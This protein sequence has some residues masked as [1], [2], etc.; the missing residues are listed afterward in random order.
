MSEGF[1]GPN[2][3]FV[4]VTGKKM[5]GEGVFLAPPHPE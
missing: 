1:G 4:E 5:V 2:P 3:M